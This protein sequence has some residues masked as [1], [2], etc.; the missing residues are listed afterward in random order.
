MSS[1][2]QLTNQ[3]T[4]EQIAEL[5]NQV[6]PSIKK[7]LRNGHT[8]GDV[9]E[10]L[11][12]YDV[13]TTVAVVEAYHTGVNK[14]KRG[15]KSKSR[16]RDKDQDLNSLI[17]SAAEIEI[18]AEKVEIIRQAF[19]EQAEVRKGLTKEEL[20]AQLSEPIE[21]MLAAHYTYEDISA[22]IA[23]AG[24]KIAP[25]TIK[26]YYQGKRK[27]R[28]KAS[29]GGQTSSSNKKSSNSK[30]GASSQAG[31]KGNQ[32]VKSKEDNLAQSSTK[33]AS[34]SQTSRGKGKRLNESSDDDELEKEFNW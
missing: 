19:V 28:S 33:S 5:L 30:S 29:S 26:S 12:Q 3:E 14:V 27:T 17:D 15:K 22:V 7:M 10:L 16:D 11:G 31:V 24:V 23:E 6:K 13:V 18:T 20:V 25:A 1:F 2:P 4:A 9:V 34:K 32:Q 21:K 8:Y